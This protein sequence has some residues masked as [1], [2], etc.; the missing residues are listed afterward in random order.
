MPLERVFPSCQSRLTGCWQPS[1]KE[2]AMQPFEFTSPKTKEQVPGLLGNNWGEVEILA[3][4]TDLLSLMKDDITT[5]RRLV[6][7]KGI[8]ELHGVTFS[9]ATGLRI[10]ALMTLAELAEHA[11]IKRNYPSLAS[12]LGEAA[13]P[14]IRNLATLGGNLCQ[15]PRCWYFRTGHGLLGQ[16]EDGKSMVV[17]GDNRYQ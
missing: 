14:Q 3:G 6:N 7:I 1:I 4:G 9:A 16:S 17:D 8:S 5:P 12:A 2:A 11:D 13:S 15:R 10:G